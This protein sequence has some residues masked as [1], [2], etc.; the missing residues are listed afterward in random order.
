MVRQ[1]SICRG[2]KGLTPPYGALSPQ[3]F[4]DPKKLVKNSQKYIAAW[5]YHKSSTVHG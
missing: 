2:V 1:C 4:I 5:F 3:V